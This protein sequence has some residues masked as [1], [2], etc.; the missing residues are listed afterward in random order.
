MCGDSKGIV[1][2]ADSLLPQKPANHSICLRGGEERGEE[3]K[4]IYIYIYMYIY[5]TCIYIYIFI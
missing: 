5:D 2:Y 1:Q 3:Q 4:H